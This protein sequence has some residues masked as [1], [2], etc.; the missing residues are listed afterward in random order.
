MSGDLPGLGL[1]EYS[2][3][4]RQ[5]TVRQMNA[6]E[7][8]LQLKRSRV[9]VVGAGGLGCPA[10]MY[11]VG[12]GIGTIGIVDNDTVEVLN[13]HRQVLHSTSKVGL[14]KAESARLYLEDLNPLVEIITHEVRLTAANAFEIIGQYDVVLDCTDTPVTR[15]LIN[16]VGVILGK[17]IVSGSGVQAEG[18]LTILNYLGGP[19]YRCFYPVPPS[20]GNVTS[21]SDGGVIGPCIGIVGTMMAVETLKVL[22]QWYE[23]EPLR[24]KAYL[25]VYSGFHDPALQSIRTFMMRRKQKQCLVCGELPQVTR[26]KICSGELDYTLF[27]GGELNYDVVEASD[28]ID[29]TQYNNEFFQH[30]G[31]SHHLVDCRPAEHFKVVSLP[32]S[33]NIPLASIRGMTKKL[34]DD[35]KEI[36]VVCRY[37]NDS[38]LATK[39]LKEKWSYSNVRDL[40]GGLEKWSEVVDCKLPKY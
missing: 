35:E 15:Y 1:H 29:V 21:C 28:Q 9:L 3:Y 6:V 20:P 11:L 19:C 17:P 31:K 38:R 39:H 23:R 37:G 22:T 4:G 26:A 34:F 18:Q 25:S 14:L 12:S 32:G 36:F 7:G 2:R 16:D 30:A 27:C 10:L 24:F 8:Q 5:M 33:V 40:K 13:L